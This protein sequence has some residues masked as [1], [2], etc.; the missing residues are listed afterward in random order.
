MY[1]E[2]DKDLFI[3][4]YW[5]DTKRLNIKKLKFSISYIHEADMKNYQVYSPLEYLSV[6]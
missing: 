1:Q 5:Y 3:I 6:L 4:L 2:V